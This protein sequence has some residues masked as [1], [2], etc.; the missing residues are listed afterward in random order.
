M[1]KRPPRAAVEAAI[2]DA[3][4]NLT[5]AAA[6]LHCTRASLYTWVYQ[7]G[8][9]K[10]AGIALIDAESVKVTVQP[11]ARGRPRLQ[12]M[13]AAAVEQEDLVQ[14]R[15]VRLPD[16]LWRLV[17]IE[18]IKLGITASDLVEQGLRLVLKEK[19]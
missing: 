14:A 10:L 11:S 1:T 4:G 9:D 7:F 12:A 5:R 18:A 3:G 15:T 13:G 6:S 2:K 17:R 8:L 19:E 16:S